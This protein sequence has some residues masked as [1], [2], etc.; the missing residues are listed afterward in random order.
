VATMKNLAPRGKAK[1]TAVED[2]VARVAADD[3]GRRL[4]RGQ[5]RF[6]GPRARNFQFRCAVL[7]L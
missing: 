4:S 1:K 7:I 5:E 2:G 6:R 3:A